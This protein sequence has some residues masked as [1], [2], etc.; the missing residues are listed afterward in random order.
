M[1]PAT[2]RAWEMLRVLA[3]VACRPFSSGRN[4]MVLGEGAAVLVLERASVAKARGAKPICELAGCGSSADTFDL[5]RPDPDGAFRAM[6]AAVLDAGLTPDDVDYVNAHGTGAIQ[7]DAAEAEAFR[8]LFGDR[9]G[10]VAVSSTKPVHGHPL[11]AAGAIESV[12]TIKAV[13][14]QTAPPT[15]NFLE[16]EPACGVD[17]VPHVAQNRRIRAAMSNSFAFGGINACLVVRPC[18]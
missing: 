1:T 15:L 5:L 2:F 18:A 13:L 6:R 12:I 3:P 11:G 9:I 10:Q 17:C 14:E 7:N 16:P 4:G 8:R